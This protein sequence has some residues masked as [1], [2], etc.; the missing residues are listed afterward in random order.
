MNQAV[1]PFLVIGAELGEK[2]EL[3]LALAKP[4]PRTTKLASTGGGVRE[5]E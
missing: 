3:S 4:M 5:L 1:L 2:S